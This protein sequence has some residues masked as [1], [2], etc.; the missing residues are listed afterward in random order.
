MLDRMPYP[1]L[2]GKVQ[3]MGESLGGE[4][5]RDCGRIGDI[6]P[7]EPERCGRAM[8]CQPGQAIFFEGY[9]IVVIEVVDA[10]D[11]PAAIEQGGAGVHPD[12]AGGSRDEDVRGGVGGGMAWHSLCSRDM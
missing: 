10:V 6:E 2:R 9:R 8:P 3:D 1:R 5:G 7:G 11:P 4:Q 12:E